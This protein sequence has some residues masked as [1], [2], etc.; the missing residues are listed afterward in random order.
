MEDAALPP[1][2]GPSDVISV[3][4]SEGQSLLSV[5]NLCAAEQDL[6]AVGR[7]YDAL[8]ERGVLRSFGSYQSS[9]ESRTALLRRVTSS[10]WCT[11]LLRRLKSS[12]SRTTACGAKRAKLVHSANCGARRT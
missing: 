5:L 12:E 10:E 8:A 7:T 3:S 2:Q 11:A 6:R 1:S 4:S 9:S